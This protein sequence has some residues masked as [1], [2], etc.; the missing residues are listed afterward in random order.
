MA[1]ITRGMLNEAAPS[2]FILVFLKY[3][4]SCC[5]LQFLAVCLIY[6][7]IITDCLDCFFHFGRGDHVGGKFDPDGGISKIYRSVFDSRQ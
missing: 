4:L 2:V 3:V 1:I 7:Y 5:F 6:Y